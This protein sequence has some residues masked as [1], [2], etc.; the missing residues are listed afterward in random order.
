[1]DQIGTVRREDHDGCFSL[2]LLIEN[3]AKRDWNCVYSTAPGNVGQL[4]PSLYEEIGGFTVVVGLLPGI[5]VLEREH[6]G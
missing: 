4:W 1:M 2:W 3:T 6:N 5:P